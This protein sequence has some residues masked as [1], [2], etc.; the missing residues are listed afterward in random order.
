MF[1]SIYELAN[2]IIANNA[3][4]V[5]LNMR[6]HIPA[7]Y[8]A[9][10]PT[11]TSELFWARVDS[12]EVR[13]KASADRL[14]LALLLVPINQDAPFASELSEMS[15]NGN[16]RPAIEDALASE[17]I[18]DTDTYLEQYIPKISDYSV[19]E[20]IVLLLLIFLLFLGLMTSLKLISRIFKSI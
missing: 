20:F 8:H 7:L 12:V 14:L 19:A 17:P 11:L 1:L 5:E 10:D 16:L 2:L 4:Q 18:A 3:Y 6:S 9:Y 13:S 15:L